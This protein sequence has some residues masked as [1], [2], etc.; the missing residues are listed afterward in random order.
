MERRPHRVHARAQGK[1]Q[2]CNGT[3]TARAHLPALKAGMSHTLR[4]WVVCKA[5]G[6][7]AL[8]AALQCP[9]VVARVCEWEVQQPLQL[10]ATVDTALQCPSITVRVREWE[11]QQPL[12]QCPTVMVHVHKWEVQVGLDLPTPHII[13]HQSCNG[14]CTSHSCTRATT[15]GASHCCINT[16][17][18]TCTLILSLPPPP[19]PEQLWGYEYPPAAHG[20]ARTCLCKQLVTCHCYLGCSMHLRTAPGV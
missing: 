13:T 3:E 2:V 7:V 11:V 1:V 18:N 16:Q 12:Q 17:S 4:L 14:C 15:A 10:R 9:A 5:P 8:G 19:P 20:K 6:K